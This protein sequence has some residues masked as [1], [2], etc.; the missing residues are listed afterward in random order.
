MAPGAPS[1]GIQLAAAADLGLGGQLMEDAANV[2][3]KLRKKKP[4]EVGGSVADDLG[5]D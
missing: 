1:A 2:A 4:G 5:L 3:K